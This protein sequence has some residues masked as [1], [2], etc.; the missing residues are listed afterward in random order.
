MAQSGV[1]DEQMH[2]LEGYLKVMQSEEA[3]S[4]HAIDSV[5]AAVNGAGEAMKN[6]FNS[7]SVDL[8]QSCESLC[9]E[10]Q[11]SSLKSAG[12]VEKAFKVMAMMLDAVVHEA[13]EYVDQEKNAAIE[14]SAMA[15]NNANAEV[16]PPSSYYLYDILIP[17]V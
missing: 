13:R 5:Q 9:N 15:K 1:I 12:A 3:V 16:R 2:R 17:S 4:E 11:T 14:L 10:I 8:K 7:W 6:G